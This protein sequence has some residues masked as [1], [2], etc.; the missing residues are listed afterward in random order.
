MR[1]FFLASNAFVVPVRTTCRHIQ[2]KATRVTRGIMTTRK[3]RRDVNEKGNLYCVKT[4]FN[5]IF[6]DPQLAATTLQ[7]VQLVSPI[8]IASNILA[9]L[10]V[11][12]CL[13]TE[14]NVPA[15]SQKFFSNC[16]YAVSHSTGPQAKQF[17]RAENVELAESLDMYLQQ[18]P[19]DHPTPERPTYIKDVSPA[20][21]DPIAALAMSLL[22]YI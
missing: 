5:T 21:I 2:V 6:T 12:R 19:T 4:G 10:H 13:E 15:L 22:L 1:R 17:N 18:L 20:R 9:N 8:L 7:A 14:G 16:M 11:L 3:A